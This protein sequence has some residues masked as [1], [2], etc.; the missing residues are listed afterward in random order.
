[1]SVLPPSVLTGLTASIKINDN[2]LKSWTQ[3]NRIIDK[4]HRHTCGIS[5]YS[6]IRTLL[7]RNKLWNGGVRNF[8]VE[9][10]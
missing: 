9:I 1:M 7:Q 3:T 2:V 4:V 5:N 6:D 8:L 10:I